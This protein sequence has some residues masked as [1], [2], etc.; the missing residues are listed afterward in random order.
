MTL[1]E[2]AIA[3]CLTF[4]N[5]PCA[6]IHVS[7]TEQLG[8]RVKGLTNLYTSGR[9]EIKLKPNHL[10][11]YGLQRTRA[12][13]VHEFAHAATYLQGEVTRG[14]SPLFRRNCRTAARKLGTPVQECLA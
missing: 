5:L 1:A 8:G 6:D 7:D 4:N 11:D 2:L 10:A 3:V 13:L 14:H 12:L 9:V